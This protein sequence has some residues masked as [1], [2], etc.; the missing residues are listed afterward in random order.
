MLSGRAFQSSHDVDHRISWSTSGETSADASEREKQS[1]LDRYWRRGRRQV[2]R[3]KAHYLLFHVAIDRPEVVPARSRPSREQVSVG[4]C[5]VAACSQATAAMT[6]AKVGDSAAVDSLTRARREDVKAVLQGGGP[7]QGKARR[8]PAR[9]LGGGRWVT[10]RGLTLPH[11]A[12]QS[13]GA[14]LENHL[15]RTSRASHWTSRFESLPSLAR[16]AGSILVVR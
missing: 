9:E 1:L 3:N 7:D 16:R 15:I 12:E 6:T 14:S 10:R 4:F 8:D 2:C 13:I 5:S 11:P